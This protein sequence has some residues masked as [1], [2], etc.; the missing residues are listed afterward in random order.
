LVKDGDDANQG[1]V[2]EG[3]EKGE[4]IDGQT[5]LLNGNVKEHTAQHAQEHGAAVDHVGNETPHESELVKDDYDK[6][7]GADEAHH[8]ESIGE[9]FGERGGFGVR[10]GVEGKDRVGAG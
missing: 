9:A 6:G 5:I 4:C 8:D 3:K 10:V 7:E 1:K 2:V